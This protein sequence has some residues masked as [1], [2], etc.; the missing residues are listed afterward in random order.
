M[1][2]V[3]ERLSVRIPKKSQVSA[4]NRGAI[5]HIVWIFRWK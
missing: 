3:N 5:C 4:V 1:T 2:A